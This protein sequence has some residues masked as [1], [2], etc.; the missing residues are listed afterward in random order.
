MLSNND[1]CTTTRGSD[2]KEL[3]KCLMFFEWG[4]SRIVSG[5]RQQ[6]TFHPP[7]RE[8]RQHKL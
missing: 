7:N 3:E 4:L 1:L 2:N 6:I 8:Y 5:K